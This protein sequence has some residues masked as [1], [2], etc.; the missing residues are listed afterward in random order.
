MLFLW[1]QQLE[2]STLC[3]KI[4]PYHKMY[5]WSIFPENC[6]QITAAEFEPD[7]ENMQP[8]RTIRIRPI[9]YGEKNIDVR[10]YSRHCTVIGQFLWP[11]NL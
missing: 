8:T 9:K 6:L 5:S 2:F 10:R 1:L 3:P 7:W 11:N 4:M